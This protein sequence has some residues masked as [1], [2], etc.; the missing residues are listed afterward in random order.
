MRFQTVPVLVRFKILGRD[1]D[2]RPIDLR[3]R[4]PQSLNRLR[5]LKVPETGHSRNL[6]PVRIET[7]FL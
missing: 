2:P 4:D 5:R 1:T 6:A 7:G 3:D